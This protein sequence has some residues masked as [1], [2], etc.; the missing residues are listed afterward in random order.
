MEIEA[1]EVVKVNA[2]TLKIHLKVSDRFTA[3]LHSA[4]GT[5]LYEQDDGYVPDFMPGK[6][7]GDY[8]MLDIDIDSGQITNWVA[9]T[10]EQ[11]QEWISGDSED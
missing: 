4:T 3:S 9:P 6:H 2:K 8:V 7:Y 1:T 10:A 11:I 5:E